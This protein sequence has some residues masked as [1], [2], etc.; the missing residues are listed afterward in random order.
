VGCILSLSEAPI[1]KKLEGVIPEF[2]LRL[3]RI[4]FLTFLFF[5]IG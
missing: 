3:C 4:F 2:A 1:K 5:S